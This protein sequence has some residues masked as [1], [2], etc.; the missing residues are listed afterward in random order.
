[1]SDVW[2]F[3]NKYTIDSASGKDTT[4]YYQPKKVDQEILH[5]LDLVSQVFYSI[6]RIFKALN[7]DGNKKRPCYDRILLSLF[8]YLVIN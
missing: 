3:R 7:L 1:M 5:L 6:N 8:T 4:N 2:S